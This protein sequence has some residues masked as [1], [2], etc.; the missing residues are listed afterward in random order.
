LQNKAGTRIRLAT[1][2]A[3]IKSKNAVSNSVRIVF[4]LKYKNT[5]E[6]AHIKSTK[7]PLFKKRNNGKL[8][9]MSIHVLVAQLV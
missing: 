8:K 4:S 5:T 3:N 6:L 1:A 7:N 9:F 2:R